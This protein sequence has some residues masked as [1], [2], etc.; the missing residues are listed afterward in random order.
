MNQRMKHLPATIGLAIS[1]A[2]TA[3]SAI[4]PIKIESQ[5]SVIGDDVLYSIGGGSAVQMGSAGQ[6]E[7]I[8]VGAGWQ[9][10]LIC[11]NMDLSNTLQNQLNGATQGFQQIMSSVRMR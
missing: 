8:T 4:D 3:A 2:S 11:G 1:L 10:N 6:M 5:G 9:N 7:S